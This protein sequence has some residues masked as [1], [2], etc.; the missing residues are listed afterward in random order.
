M[1]SK[2]RTKTKVDKS[3]DRRIAKLERQFP[4]VN[5]VVN[6]QASLQ[7]TDTTQ[8]HIYSLLP[9]ALDSEKV[10]LRGYRSRINVLQGLSASGEDPPGKAKV[11]CVM[12]IYKCN[13]DYATA[14]S[15][16]YTAPLV[17][18]IFNSNGDKT[19]A[20]YNPD[21]QS[22][23]RIIFDR[24][25]NTNFRELN[26]LIVNF[27]NYKKSISFMPLTDK[28]F[29]LRPFLIVVS[30]DTLAGSPTATVAHDTDLLTRQMP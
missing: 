13:A 11:R 15:P 1:V 17:N 3:Q 21:N 18:D 14:G 4:S 6:S 7:Y 22:R 26:T 5:E 2:P 10:E 8:S 24:T 30:A 12:L 16:T 9:A 28:A 23:M 19:L 27:K 29:V 20:N 25:I